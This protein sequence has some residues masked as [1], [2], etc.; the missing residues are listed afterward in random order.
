MALSDRMEFQAICI[1][2]DGVL[3]VRL[4]R[5]ILDGGELA[6]IPTRQTYTPDMDPATL[7]NKVRQVANLVWTQAVIDA[8]KAAH[9][10][11]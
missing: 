8:Y 7:P 4:D 9:P 2:A 5:V 3:E 11:V 10:G 6:R 1:K